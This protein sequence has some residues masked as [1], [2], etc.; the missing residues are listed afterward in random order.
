[1]KLNAEKIF[2]VLA[3]LALAR[4]IAIRYYYDITPTTTWK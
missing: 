3:V 4:T 1:M 2:T